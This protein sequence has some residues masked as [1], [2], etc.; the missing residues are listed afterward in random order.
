MDNRTLIEQLKSGMAK[1]QSPFL[2][3]I[4]TYNEIENIGN[5]IQRLDQTVS[6]S[7]DIL[8]IDDNSPDGTAGEVEALQNNRNNLY[9]LKRNAKLGLGSAY[10]DGFRIGIQCGADYIITMDSDLSHDPAVI[11]QM[12][13]EIE[14]YDLIIGS[15]YTH[16][17]QV[18]D[19]EL[20]R[21]FLSKGGNMIAR[22][23]LNLP[24]KDSTSGF[25]CYRTSVLSDLNLEERIK[26]H[27]YIFLVELLA[28]LVSMEFRIKEIPISFMK[29][30]EGKTKVNIQE[31]IH[32]LWTIVQ[33]RARN[34]ISK[35]K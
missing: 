25:R 11:N 17:G 1:H 20:W 28:L 5:I 24:T 19:L 9:L 35:G 7:L 30:L 32:G 22:T 33:L 4:P 21:L 23:L 12:I 6:L 29:R 31:M 10:M 27:K 18:V 16:G 34:G 8:V 14:N 3:V 13:K 26:S 2:V 15:R